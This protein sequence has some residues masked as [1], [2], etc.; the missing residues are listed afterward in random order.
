MIGS[1]PFSSHSFRIGAATSAAVAGIPN[2]VIHLATVTGAT[3]DFPRTSFFN[4]L[5]ILFETGVGAGNA[6]GV[7]SCLESPSPALLEGGVGEVNSRHQT[8][9]SC[10]MVRMTLQPRRQQP[11]EDHCYLACQ[12]NVDAQTVS[13]RA[14]PSNVFYA[15]LLSV[16]Q[17][18]LTR[19]L[20]RVR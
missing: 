16:F 5:A 3:F 9:F 10:R 15:A 7:G 8:D 6:F 11:S 18:L 20:L 4:R 14:T 19:A 1:G 2:H 12:E 17:S 13:N